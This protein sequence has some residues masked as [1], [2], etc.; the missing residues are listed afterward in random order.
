MNLPRCASN[1]TLRDFQHLIRRFLADDT[2]PLSGEV[3]IDETFVGGK[4]ATTP[5]TGTWF[6]PLANKTPVIGAVER[7]DRV[8][9]RVIPSVRKAILLPIVREHVMPHATVFTDEHRAYDTLAKSGYS[10]HRVNHSAKVY[11]RGN[12]HTNTI[13]GFWSRLK[14]GIRGAHHAVG[15][16]YLQT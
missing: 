16:A 5:S 1:T 3:G 15:A 10:H 14:N 13:E 9:A 11:V 4:S 2:G 12:V 8:K 6:D 7:G